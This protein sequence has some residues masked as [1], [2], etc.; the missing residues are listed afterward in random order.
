MV[1]TPKYKAS[2]SNQKK[3]LARRPEKV[4]DDCLAFVAKGACMTQLQI[5]DKTRQTD[6][7]VETRISDQVN[8]IGA[9]ACREVFGEICTRR[10]T[11]CWLPASFKSKISK[12]ARLNC[13]RH[14]NALLHDKIGGNPN[15][16]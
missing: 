8:K 6:L 1:A 14:G 12:A 16:E 13:Y 15:R 2:S 7:Y 11:R 4:Q 10:I 9:R 5:E 3:R